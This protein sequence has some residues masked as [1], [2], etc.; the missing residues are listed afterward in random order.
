[1]FN[2]STRP[3]MFG[4]RLMFHETQMRPNLA[5][6]R[7]ARDEALSEA[8]DTSPRPPGAARMP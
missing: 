5:L 6:P 1:M 8:I 7:R 3:F 4:P 2:A